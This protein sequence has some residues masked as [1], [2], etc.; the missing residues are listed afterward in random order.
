MTAAANG[1]SIAIAAGT[2]AESVMT[3]RRLNFLGAGGGTIE[4]AAG[5]TTIAPASG[6]AL[7]LNNGGSVRAIRALGAS[8]FIDSPGIVFPPP[9]AARATS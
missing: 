1:D 6:S 7:I 5:T 2:Y 4:S 9:P 8:S 3:D